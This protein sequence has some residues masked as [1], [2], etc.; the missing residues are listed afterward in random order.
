MSVTPNEKTPSVKN[1]ALRR[2][3]HLGGFAHAVTSEASGT[4]L[5]F[6]RPGL[7]VGLCSGACRPHAELLIWNWRH[8]VA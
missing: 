6:G 1:G 3:G 7:V 4:S 5:V 8:S 2:G